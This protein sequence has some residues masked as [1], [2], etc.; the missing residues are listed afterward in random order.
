MDVSDAV[1]EWVSRDDTDDNY[2]NHYKE[3]T[4]WHMINLYIDVKDIEL[5]D[6]DVV[7]QSI[8]E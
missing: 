3:L 5:V 8:V 1:H 4:G 6:H 7:I 2:Q